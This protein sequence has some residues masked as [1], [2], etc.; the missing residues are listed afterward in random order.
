MESKEFMEH[1]TNDHN[2]TKEQF[3]GK[4]QMTMHIDGATYFMSTYEWE[5]ETGLK[6]TQCIEMP[7]EKD[8]PMRYG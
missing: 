3:K 4:K 5:L 2:L 8:D 1:I 6:F 7:R